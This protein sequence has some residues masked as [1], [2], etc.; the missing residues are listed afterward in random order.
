MVC[1]PI[2][3]WELKNAMPHAKFLM[4]ADAGHS[5]MEAGITSA[6]VE[7]TEAFRISHQ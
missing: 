6:L 4:I 3:A 5:A 1:P 2:S 7:A